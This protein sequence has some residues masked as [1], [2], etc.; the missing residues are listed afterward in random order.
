MT[1]LEVQRLAALHRNVKLEILRGEG[2]RQLAPRRNIGISN[3][4]TPAFTLLSSA[5]RLSS[6]VPSRPMSHSKRSS[7][8]TVPLATKSG[9][10][11]NRLVNLVVIDLDS[12]HCAVGSTA[13]DVL[14]GR[15]C[16]AS[17]QP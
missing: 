14:Q 16:D 3:I 9:A 7:T 10:Q 11:C 5:A 8:L 6:S 15:T 12:A 2:R 17:A 13:V 4:G 1:I